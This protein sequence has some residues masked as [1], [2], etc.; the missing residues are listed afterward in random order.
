MDSTIRI[1]GGKAL[2]G[3]V[4]LRG[5]KNTIPKSMVAALLSEETST[6]KNIAHVEDVGIMSGLIELIGGE[7]E[8]VDDT[9]DRKSVV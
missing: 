5:A 3:E 2:S 4:V 7:V 8:K 9:T 1:I 6:L